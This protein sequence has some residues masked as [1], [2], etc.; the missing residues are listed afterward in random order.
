[1]F[2]CTFDVACK[3]HIFS[4]EILYITET[5]KLNKYQL[6]LVNRML[7]FCV[8]TVHYNILVMSGLELNFITLGP[9][10]RRSLSEYVE[11]F[12]DITIKNN[13]FVDNVS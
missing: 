7:R 5:K 11:S 10:R 2:I 9:V 3:M 6:F 12:I 1:M 8:Y 4:M 13:L